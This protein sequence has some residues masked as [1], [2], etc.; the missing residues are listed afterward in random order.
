MGE[1]NNYDDKNK[2]LSETDQMPVSEANNIESQKSDKPKNKKKLIIAIVAAVLVIVAIVVS[3]WIFFINK[4]AES[5][6]ENSLT[7]EELVI[8]SKDDLEAAKD[9]LN[10]TVKDPTEEKESLESE[11]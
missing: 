1:E 9:I 4:P 3:V 10:N 8:D 6:Q 2:T 5:S 11:K 7:A